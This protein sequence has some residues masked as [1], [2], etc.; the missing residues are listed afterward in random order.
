MRD[1]WD[2]L[3]LAAESE[4]TEARD[5]RRGETVL[6]AVVPTAADW[7]HLCR[8]H[9]YRIPLS[10]VPRHVGADYMAFYHPGAGTPEGQSDLRWTITYYAPVDNYRLVR[11]QELL[12]DEA[13]HPRAA[14]L[15]YKVELGALQR[16]PRP[17]ASRR[18]RRIAFIETTLPRLL[19]AREINDLWVRE[20]PGAR[21]DRVSQVGE[22]WPTPL[23]PGAG[24]RYSRSTPGT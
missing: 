23:W 1:L 11:R 15:Y 9:W 4:A 12:P 3:S 17:I 8:E 13:D 7:E 21:W 2:D 14:D 10:R 20:R 22:A 6:V 19:V 5:H 24:L 18:L 16:L